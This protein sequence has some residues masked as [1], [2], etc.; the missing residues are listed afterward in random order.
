MYSAIYSQSPPTPSIMA[1]RLV[2]PDRPSQG[3][4]ARGQRLER[5]LEC[6]GGP[7]GCSSLSGCSPIGSE[8]HGAHLRNRWGS[9]IAP[10]Q[11]LHALRAGSCMQSRLTSCLSILRLTD[12]HATLKHAASTHGRP[13]TRL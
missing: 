6:C 11:E 4:Q 9:M 5:Q 1:E 12:R 7:H 8:A 3:S 13:L 10:L 2:W